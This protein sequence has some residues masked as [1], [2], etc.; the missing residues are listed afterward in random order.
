MLILLSTERRERKLAIVSESYALL[1]SPVKDKISKKSSCAIE[2]IP[3]EQLQHH[4]FRRLSPHEV[5]GFIGL[6]E[7]DGL[8][9]IGVITG[10]TKVAS[11]I[12]HEI[13]N[14]IY[15]IDFFCLND[16]TWDF[17]ELDQS[18]KPIAGDMND[19]QEQQLSRH[20]CYDVRKLMSNGSFYYSNDFDLTTTLQNRGFKNEDNLVNDDTIEEEYMWNSFLMEEILAYRD[21]LDSHTKHIVDNEGFLTTV[22]R[23]FAETFVTYIK[24]LKIELTVISKQSWKRAGTRF[25]ARG[26]DDEGNVANFVETE[27]IM[28]SNE[29]CYAFTQ[30]RGSVPIFWE[31]D[32]A[33]MNAKVTITRSLEATQP[34]FD[35]HFAKLISKYGPVNIINL[36]STKSNDIDLA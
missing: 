10:K 28:Y 6:L 30:V 33:I 23:G 24:R 15:A 26:I 5:H 14:K 2:L 16:N 27:L 34:V 21:R 17:I 31:Q 11:P 8:I 18:G 9:F 1:F 12:P 29:Y 32:A 13:I 25:N 22:I 20:P 36:L 19:L 4:R 7:I 3:K 35:E